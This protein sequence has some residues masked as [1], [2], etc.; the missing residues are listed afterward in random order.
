MTATDTTFVF[1][2][3]PGVNPQF[4]AVVKAV[5]DL[6]GIAPGTAGFHTELL[7]L[8]GLLRYQFRFEEDMMGSHNYPQMA[9]HINDHNILRRHLANLIGV[10]PDRAPGRSS[11]HGK[12]L[13]ELRKHIRNLDNE[14]ITALNRHHRQTTVKMN[15]MCFEILPLDTPTPRPP[16]HLIPEVPWHQPTRSR[17]CSS[18]SRALMTSSRPN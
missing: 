17:N 12:F 14:F 5:R 4:M 8:A 10:T 16:D 3:Y 6:Q 7:D 11:P 2:E 1:S 9:A 15:K 18:A 13:V